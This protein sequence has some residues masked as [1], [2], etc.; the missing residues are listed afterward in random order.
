MQ[1]GLSRSPGRT[2]APD[3]P[4]LTCSTT[5]VQW[6]CHAFR[7]FSAHGAASSV[8]LEPSAPSLPASEVAHSLSRK[9]TESHRSSSG[10]PKCVPYLITL[11]QVQRAKEVKAARLRLS[12]K[13]LKAPRPPHRDPLN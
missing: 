1:S 6:R 4:A 8:T 3:Q 7:S 5:S 2:A 11:E 9:T 12:R 13:W 10:V